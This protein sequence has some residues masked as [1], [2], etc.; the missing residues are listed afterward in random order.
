MSVN[1]NRAKLNKAEDGRGYHIIWLDELYPMYWEEG[2]NFHPKYRRGFK[3]PNKYIQWYKVRVYRTWKHNR[4][5]Q[6]KE[7]KLNLNKE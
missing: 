1:K 7:E 6:W 5:T 4:K 2:M 3:N